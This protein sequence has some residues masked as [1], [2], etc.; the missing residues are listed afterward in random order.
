MNA[1]RASVCPPISRCPRKGKT[2]HTAVLRSLLEVDLEAYVVAWLR[3]RLDQIA[4]LALE[5]VVHAILD[6]F[7]PAADIHGEEK[8]GLAIWSGEVKPDVIEVNELDVDRAR[9][10][11]LVRRCAA[12]RR[13][14]LT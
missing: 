5:D 13:R 11:E 9:P 14:A 2:G 8:G 6:E 7:V 12:D 3:L 4:V 10:G 1:S